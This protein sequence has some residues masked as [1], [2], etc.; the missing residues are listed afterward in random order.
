MFG[1]RGAPPA[2]VAALVVVE[3]TETG[4]ALYPTTTPEIAARATMR[5]GAV[6]VDRAT[7]PSQTKQIRSFIDEVN[8]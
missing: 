3:Y 7:T 8:P 4:A 2:Y 6:E 5:C 1:F